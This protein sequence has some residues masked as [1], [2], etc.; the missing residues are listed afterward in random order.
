MTALMIM[1]ACPIVTNDYPCTMGIECYAAE[2]TLSAPANVVSK[3]KDNTVTL[4]WDKVKG[5]DAYRIYKYDAGKKKYVKYKSVTGNK[6]VIKNLEEGASY[7]FKIAALT[8]SG[9]SYKAGKTSKTVTV[10]ISKAENTK[11][12]K[13]EFKEVTLSA[14]DMLGAWKYYD[15]RYLVDISKS[16]KYDPSQKEWIY[17]GWMTGLQFI[18]EKEI[19]RGYTDFAELG[20]YNAS[21]KKIGNSSYKTFTDGTDYYLFY[22]FENGDGMST[23]VFKKKAVPELQAVSDVSLLSGYWTAVDFCPF[24]LNNKYNYDPTFPMCTTNLYLTNANVKGKDITLYFSDGGEITHKISSN[25][26][27]D[28][29]YYV[30]SVGDDM[31]MYYQWINGDG[32][33]QFYV[34]KKDK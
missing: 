5:A 16:S 25:K 11:A 28:A 32:D 21:S 17:A 15:F 3:V 9:K 7:K 10:S 33:K 8:K 14:K 2:S 4:S 22:S 19:I 18:S 30:Y 23:Y 31:Y 13:A 12:Q 27:G 1:S 26:I 29:K 20:Q 34:L 6:I 24:E